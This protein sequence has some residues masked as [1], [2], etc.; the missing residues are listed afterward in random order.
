MTINTFEQLER[1][2]SVMEDLNLTPQEKEDIKLG[3][4]IG[5]KGIYCINCEKCIKQ[6]PYNVDV[7][8]IMRSYMYAYGYQKP[9]KAKETLKFMDIQNIRCNDCLSCNIDCTMGFDI[10]NKVIDITRVLNMPDEF[11][12]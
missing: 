12:G 11:L 3:Q 5:S 6:C 7:P 8:K 4:A 2:M 1:Y 10:K 9:S